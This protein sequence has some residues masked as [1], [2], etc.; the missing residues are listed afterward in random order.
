MSF[1]KAM[2]SASD[3]LQS[4]LQNSKSPLAQ[5]FLRWKLWRFWDE[6]V[7]STWAAIS[8]PVDYDRGKLIVWVES[9]THLYEMTY[10]LEPMKL[11]INQYLR[12]NFVHS[13]RLTQNR[14]GF[15]KTAAQLAH[16]LKRLES[17]PKSE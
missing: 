15:A 11:K 3:V 5:Q 2:K 14:H 17:H 7:G 13:I 8:K 9:S 16:D 4:L 1:C 6:I 12:Q 10:V